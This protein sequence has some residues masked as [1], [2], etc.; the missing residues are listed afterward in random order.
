MWGAGASRRGIE[1]ERSALG[2]A[3]SSRGERGDVG[4]RMTA[5][6]AGSGLP[7]PV[8]DGLGRSGPVWVALGRSGPWWAGSGGLDR[9]RFG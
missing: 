2:G 7:G 3:M 9:F 5:F 4:R 1:E 6:G 8:Q